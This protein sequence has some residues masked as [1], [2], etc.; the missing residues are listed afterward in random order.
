MIDFTGQF[1]TCLKPGLMMDS[2][3]DLFSHKFLLIT[4][5]FF[6]ITSAVCEIKTEDNVTGYYLFRRKE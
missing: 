6:D 4:L 2:Q 3:D 1:H 5:T